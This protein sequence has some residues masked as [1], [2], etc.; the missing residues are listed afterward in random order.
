MSMIDGKG[1]AWVNGEADTSSV[2]GMPTTDGTSTE[3][4]HLGN[5]Y[6]KITYVR[7]AS[8][9]EYFQINGDNA[10]EAFNLFKTD[11]EYEFETAI[12]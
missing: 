8:P 6:A 10:T 4:G 11:Y 7:D 1:Y 12:F 2:I 9:I 3:V 5:G